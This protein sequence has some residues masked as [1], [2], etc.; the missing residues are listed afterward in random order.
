MVRTSPLNREDY[1]TY[2][3]RWECC[4][5]AGVHLLLG[6]QQPACTAEMLHTFQ[7]V[8]AFSIGP[9]SVSLDITSK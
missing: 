1:V 2:S 6:T 5:V 7:L 3:G 4:G 9:P 8:V